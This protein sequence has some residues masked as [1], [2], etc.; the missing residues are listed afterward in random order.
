ME[1]KVI[2][3]RLDRMTRDLRQKAIEM[4]E[5]ITI[6]RSLRLKDIETIKQLIAETEEKLSYYKQVLTHIEAEQW[7][8]SL[9]K[10]KVAEPATD[11][12]VFA[13]AST[14]DEA[15]GDVATPE[16]RAFKLNGKTKEEVL[17]SGSLLEKIR[18]YLCYFDDNSYADSKGKLTPE[19]EERIRLS[20]KSK[21][22]ADKVRGYLNEYTELNRFG[23]QLRYYFKRYQT[24]FS[25]LAKL[26]NE[27]DNQDRIAQRLTERARGYL[28]TP[29]NTPLE[30]GDVLE[31]EEERRIAFGA[32]LSLARNMRDDGIF[33]KWDEKAQAFKANVYEMGGLYDK[34]LQEAKETAEALSDFKAIAV[35]AHEFIRKSELHYTP[36]SIEMALENALQERYTR[37][38]VKNLKYFRS[39]YLRKRRE[40]GK[41]LTKDETRRAIIPDFLETK[42]NKD[43]LRAARATLK[44]NI[45]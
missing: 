43:F 6:S 17:E 38:L 34:A 25:A 20:I 7:A 24:C 19:E 4:E 3:A 23:G 18:L 15:E 31:S 2:R 10:R 14:G 13:Q 1:K 28:D 45:K 22:D 35:A 36:I 37:Y 44:S 41:P 9:D 21:E 12:R 33:I 8:E 40:T 32:L 42:P 39:E 26:L 5:A 11:E 30:D 16:E 29:L 27:W